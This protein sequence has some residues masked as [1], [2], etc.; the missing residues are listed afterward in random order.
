ER[1]VCH[2]LKAA[3]YPQARRERISKRHKPPGQYA[4]DRRGKPDTLDD[5]GVL[6]ARKPEIDDER[7]SHGPGERI[8]EL[9]QHDECEHDER[10]VA[11]EEIS[12]SAI[13]R[14]GHATERA[15]LGMRRMLS[16]RKG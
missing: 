15:L 5:G 7:G 9:E 4:G 14:D 12:E 8:G 2:R 10:S 1:Q 11:G 13:G 6:V 16:R 3:A